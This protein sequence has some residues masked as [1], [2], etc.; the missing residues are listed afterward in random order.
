M[1]CGLTDI[2]RAVPESDLIELTDDENTGSY[3]EILLNNIIQ[4]QSS[5]IDGYLRG[6]YAV[7]V[8][9][10]PILKQICIDL[11]AYALTYRRMKYRMPQSI[12]DIKKGAEQK[13]LSIQKGEITL[14]SGSAESRTPHVSVK[15]KTRV[16][17]DEVLSQYI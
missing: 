15:E 12:I 1:Y 16:F 3:D 8:T 10:N 2:L 13:L 5:F 17:T 11:V 6:R 14:D 4:E 9:G 7:P